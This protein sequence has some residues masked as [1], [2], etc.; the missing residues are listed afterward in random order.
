VERSLQSEDAQPGG[1]LAEAVLCRLEQVTDALRREIH[2]TLRACGMTTGQYNVL[3]ALRSESP[4]GLTCTELGNR[5]AGSDP[6]ITRLL[7]RLAKQQLVRRRRDAHDR[8]A[9]VSEITEEGLRLLESV[10]PRLEARIQAL[11]EHMTA[12][13]LQLLVE[14]LEELAGR[15]PVRLVPQARAG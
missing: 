15:E 4:N 6:D 11:F 1:N 9:V 3:R 2:L 5:L 7:D 12:D 13:R 10:T 8:R 14:L